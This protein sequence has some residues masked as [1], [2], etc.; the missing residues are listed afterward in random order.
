[1]QEAKLVLA[2]DTLPY[3][4]VGKVGR[5]GL[6]CLSALTITLFDS[7]FI[8]VTFYLSIKYWFFLIRFY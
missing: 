2:D 3:W 6:C 8:S 5:C 7:V 4:D 1:N